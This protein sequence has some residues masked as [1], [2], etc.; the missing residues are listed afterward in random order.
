M[1]EG[2]VWGER[3]KEQMAQR[4]LTNR[5]LTTEEKQRCLDGSL[6]IDQGR[7]AASALFQGWGGGW[8]EDIEKL[9]MHGTR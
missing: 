7:G 4:M 8:R 9:G 5:V 6:I 3:K 2:G 1:E